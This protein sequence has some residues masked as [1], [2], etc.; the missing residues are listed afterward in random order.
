M[1]LHFGAQDRVVAIE[2]LHASKVLAEGAVMQ[3][4]HAAEL[5]ATGSPTLGWIATRRQEAE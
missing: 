5:P 4:P 1:F 3:L 2:A